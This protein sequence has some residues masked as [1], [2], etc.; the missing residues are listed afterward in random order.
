MKKTLLTI[1][2][3]VL[4]LIG[5]SQAW[6]YQWAAGIGSVEDD[7]ES[8]RIA[9]D[10]EDNTYIAVEYEGALSIGGADYPAPASNG[11]D[12]L[13]VKFS[14]NGEILWSGSIV[15]GGVGNVLLAG[16]RVN[17][18]HVDADDNIIV[19]GNIGPNGSVFGTSNGLTDSRNY[20]I[21]ISTD[22][23]VLWQVYADDDYLNDELT[24]V[25]SDPDGNIY[26]GG[27][28]FYAMGGVA[29]STGGIYRMAKISSDGAVEYIEPLPTGVPTRIQLDS[30]GDFIISSQYGENEVGNYALQKISAS[31]FSVIW[32]R[33]NLLSAQDTPRG[34]N[35]GFHV[36]SDDSIV[37]FL[38]TT[39]QIEY[40]DSEVANCDVFC[41]MGVLVNIDAD[42]NTVSMHT[43]ESII[44][45]P[46]SINLLGL[47]FFPTAFE[48][49][50]DDNYY[51]AGRH[52]DDV[53]FSNG[54]LFQPS[55]SYLGDFDNPEDAFVVKVDGNLTLLEY[56]SQTGSAEQ[57]GVSLAVFSNGDAALAGIYEIETF[58]GFTGNTVFGEYELSG[59]GGEDYFVAR[60]VTGSE[61]P[62]SAKDAES[63]LAFDLYP[64]P[65]KDFTNL[66]FT[67][68]DGN[69]A[70]LQIIDMTGKIVQSERIG[71]TGTVQHRIET[72]K[73]VSGLYTLR[74]TTDTS[75]GTTNFI[76]NR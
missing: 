72:A 46:I 31:D 29:Q 50:D 34:G 7:D 6:N 59:F 57:G 71:G 3:C 17:D 43:M 52:S 38:K 30:N 60:V 74:L 10:S 11:R 63:T 23:N 9:V 33:E 48:A 25:T 62:L 49:I 19:I 4:S 64:N 40:E 37:Q 58:G 42:G 55:E 27:R 16:D 51:I 61:A 12:V 54:F 13:V 53:Q 39:G 76:V 70:S 47:N 21:K 15:G 45:N 5:F 44:E 41:S 32:E 73:L 20:I 65:T 67:L 28:G 1:S 36:K 18:I 22:G 26:A 68:S 14:P 75:V 8:I 2:A 35:L 69:E 56:A 24:T 66:R